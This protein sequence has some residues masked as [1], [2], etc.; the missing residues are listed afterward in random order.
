M[1]VVKRTSEAKVDEIRTTS[2]VVVAKIVAIASQNLDAF[3]T[4]RF[5]SA[6]IFATFHYFQN[7]KH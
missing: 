6:T 2:A 4:K 3:V 7:L 1:E 5:L